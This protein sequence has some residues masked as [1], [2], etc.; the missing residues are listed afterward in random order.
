MNGR[1]NVQQLKRLLT[2]SRR[3][4]R[5]T[6]QT[7]RL[8]LTVLLIGCALTVSGCQSSSQIQPSATS[9]VVVDQSA[10]VKPSYTQT[11]LDFLSS[12]PSAQTNK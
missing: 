12:K 5:T 6:A 9:Q 2:K 1:K 11:L 4:G 3:I 10:M 7:V 8:W